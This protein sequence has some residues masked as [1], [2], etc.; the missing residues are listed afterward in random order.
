MRDVAPCALLSWFSP[1]GPRNAGAVEG[2]V[3]LV[4]HAMT[5]AASD[6]VVNKAPNANRTVPQSLLVVQL[7]LW[8]CSGQEAAG[9]MR[10]AALIGTSANCGLQMSA[11]VAGS[12]GWPRIPCSPGELW[13]RG[14]KGMP[15][16]ELGPSAMD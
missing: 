1:K 12:P 4:L 15:G 13:A 5:P 10:E 7:L 6:V 14:V 11:G 2:K 3:A 8:T 9:E 16:M